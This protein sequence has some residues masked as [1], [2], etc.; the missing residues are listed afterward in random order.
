MIC[1]AGTLD[2]HGERTADYT[3]ALL[4]M[5]SDENLSWYLD[6][7]IRTHITNPIRDLKENED[8]MESNKMHGEA[9]CW[10]SVIFNLCMK[11]PVFVEQM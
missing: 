1:S 11:T 10:V 5:V 7:N 2:L 3:Y 6:E 4:F 8:F 9:L